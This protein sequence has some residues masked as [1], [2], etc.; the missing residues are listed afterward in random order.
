MTGAEHVK[1]LDALKTLRSPL[2]QYWR[3]AYDYTY[4][5]RG[6]KFGSPWTD[7]AS[8][9]GA[10]RAQQARIYDGTAA[11]SVRILASALMS[12]L[13]PANS[14]WFGLSTYA[15]EDDQEAKTWLDGAADVLWKNIHASNYDVAAYEAM[16]DLCVSGMFALYVEPASPESGQPYLFQQWPLHSIWC[17]DSKGKGLVDTV[18]RSFTLTAQQA[19]YEYGDKVSEQITT[20]SEKN[21]DE[22]FEFITAIYPRLK[23]SR[24]EL[25]IASEHVEIKSKSIVRESGYNEMPVVVP[26]W[27]VIPDSVYSAGP[28]SDA[29]P[30]IKTLNEVKKY[31]LANADL[32]IAGMWGA[33]D[34]G[35]LNP[36][37][38]KV[39]PRKI[40]PVAN[41]DSIFPL[42]SG[43]KFDVAMLEIELLQ[44]S[45][46]ETLMSDQLQPQDGP[47]M[48]ATEVHARTQLVRQLLGPMYGR[49]QSEFLQ[50]LIKRCFGIAF[51]AGALTPAPES[52][53]GADAIITYV[54]PLA[55]AQK[56]EDVGAMDRFEANIMAIAKEGIP[57]AL[58][59]YDM[60][61]ALR[62][63]AELLGVPQ[64]LLVAGEE[65]KKLREERAAAAQAQQEQTQKSEMMRGM[66][67]QLVKGMATNAA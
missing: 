59:I 14:R 66:M 11:N 52:L 60:D 67:P 56:L 23:P 43:A 40:I 17:A 1:R 6:Q 65:V 64:D 25:P 49:L 4:P 20:A 44:R 27:L 18:Y 7:G 13:T 21:P 5:L 19:V 57:A 34:D 8:V 24:L 45:I 28:V 26:R 33:V 51:R 54:S 37:T 58:D 50:P 62:K 31:V 63:K 46:R 16:I 55:R 39:G 30:D 29:L 47:A 35:V 9:A 41:K 36:A 2:E 10:A 12:G 32:A 61:K 53:R 48:T 38:V 15:G 42:Q 22:R 3:E